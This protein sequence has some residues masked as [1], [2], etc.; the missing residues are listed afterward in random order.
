[1]KSTLES[2]NV[3]GNL[4]CPGDVFTNRFERCGLLY[5]AVMYP[6]KEKDWKVPF[7]SGEKGWTRI[8]DLDLFSC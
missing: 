2:I 5:K 8:T 7:G 6:E 1:M 3:Q 4:Y